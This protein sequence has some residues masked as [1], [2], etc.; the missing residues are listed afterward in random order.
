MKSFVRR[1]MGNKNK[2]NWMQ[3][4]GACISQP[5]IT[6][7][8]PNK[9]T[10]EMKSTN[11]I[12]SLPFFLIS[13]QGI[14]RKYW[15]RRYWLRKRRERGLP[16]QTRASNHKFNP[17]GIFGTDRVRMADTCC[18]QTFI[19]SNW[20]H[21]RNRK[22]GKPKENTRRRLFDSEQKSIKGIVCARIFTFVWKTLQ[23][24]LNWRHFLSIFLAKLFSLRLF[25]PYWTTI[26][27]TWDRQTECQ[28]IRLLSHSFSF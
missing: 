26:K 27:S 5:I 2:A 22:I 17:I 20:A 12:C 8:S 13:I 16:V 4:S 6:H 10:Q 23:L 19:Y 1:W 9:Q 14:T 15:T 25:R 11:K 21:G 24:Q 18:G 3:T 7:L 28:V